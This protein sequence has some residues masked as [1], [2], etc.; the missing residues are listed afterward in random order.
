MAGLQSTLQ[1]RWDI[2]E[3]TVLLLQSNNTWFASCMKSCCNRVYRTLHPP[4]KKKK[5]KKCWFGEPQ[6]EV[7]SLQNGLE[8]H[9]WQT[10][11]SKGA[12]SVHV[13]FYA[14]MIDA[15]QNDT[16]FVMHACTCIWSLPLVFI[17]CSQIVVMQVKLDLLWTTVVKGVWN[18]KDFDKL[19][20][21]KRGWQ[22]LALS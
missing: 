4:K 13:H 7:E 11:N 8:R 16:Y 3:V 14:Y 20:F 10:Q 17:W 22:K 18:F 12:I 9:L 15:C 19:C 21:V 5:K 6:T 2:Q 1:P